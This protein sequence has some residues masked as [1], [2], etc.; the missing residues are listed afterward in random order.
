MVNQN[1]DK[2]NKIQQAHQGK[3]LGSDRKQAPG[4]NDAE[5]NNQEDTDISVGATGRNEKLK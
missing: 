5:Y 1:F 4:I 2:F 3:Y